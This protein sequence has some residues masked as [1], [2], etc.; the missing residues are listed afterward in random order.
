M[1]LRTGLTYLGL[2]EIL[3]RNHITERVGGHAD[4]ERKMGSATN[5]VNRRLIL[6]ARLLHHACA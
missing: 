2:R 4:T 6:S 3:A 5:V 1:V